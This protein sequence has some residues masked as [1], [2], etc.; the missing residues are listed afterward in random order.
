MARKTAVV[1]SG[2]EVQYE[3]WR[4][5]PAIRIADTIYCS[6]QLG[7]AKDGSLPSD[8]AEQFANAFE[9][10]RAV[11]EAAGS[12]L[13]DIVEMTTFHIG[14]VAELET[15]ATSRNPGLRRR[16]S[17]WRNSDFPVRSSRSR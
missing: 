14:L 6:G 1:P 16:R 8:P 2:Y 13:G 9:A 11:L 4:L 5:A 3:A 12:G 7:I 10:V 17:G 15:F